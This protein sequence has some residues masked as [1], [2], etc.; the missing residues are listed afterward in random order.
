MK[1]KKFKCSAI[2]NLRITKVNSGEK[3]NEGIV[4]PKKILS[5]T[6]LFP[7]E[8]VIITK[9]GAGNWK[10]RIKTFIIEGK[11]DEVEIRGSLTKEILLV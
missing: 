10:N 3:L 9:I 5:K 7:G 8:E 4:I 11:D 1:Y 2:H 6:N